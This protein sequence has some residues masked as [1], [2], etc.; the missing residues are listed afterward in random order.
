MAPFFSHAVVFMNSVYTR[1]RV[2]SSGVG[3]GGAAGGGDG[4]SSNTFL[5]FILDDKELPLIPTY[6]TAPMHCVICFLSEHKASECLKALSKHRPKANSECCAPEWS[7]AMAAC[8]TA[9]AVA[10]FPRRSFG[11]PNGCTPLEGCLS[12]WSWNSIMFYCSSSVGSGAV[13]LMCWWA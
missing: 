10:H 7:A 8:A 4:K 5:P 1:P 11:I 6:R 3:R 12:V 2:G 13:R 9:M